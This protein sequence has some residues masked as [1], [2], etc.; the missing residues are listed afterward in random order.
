[1]VKNQFLYALHAG[2]EG[3]KADNTNLRIVIGMKEPI[4]IGWRIGSF[5]N[6]DIPRDIVPGIIGLKESIAI[7]RPFPDGHDELGT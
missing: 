3:K 5:P 2:I 4:Y 7:R 6:L 1:M